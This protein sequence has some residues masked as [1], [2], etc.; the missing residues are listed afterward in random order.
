M[1]LAPIARANV[2]ACCT[3]STASG[4]SSIGTKMWRYMRNHSLDL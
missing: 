3:V 1:T 2:T 4:E